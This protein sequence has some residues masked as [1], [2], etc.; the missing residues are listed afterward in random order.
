MGWKFSPRTFTQAVS[1][2][3]SFT[4]IWRGQAEWT[5]RSPS[6]AT[7]PVLIGKVPV[8]H[9][10]RGWRNETLPHRGQLLHADS[11]PA[12]SAFRFVRFLRVA[13]PFY[14]TQISRISQIFLVIFVW[15][16]YRFVRFLRVA[17][18]FYLTQISR[19]SQISWKNLLRISAHLLSESK[20]ILLDF[21]IDLLDFCA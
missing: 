17:H 7:H 12:S 19:I 16:C 11:W 1:M 13:H 21:V 9:V 20:V 10:S 3:E 8:D 14:L 5:N 18:P 4:V 2:N 6:Y 15:F